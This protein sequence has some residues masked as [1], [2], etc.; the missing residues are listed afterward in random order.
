MKNISLIKFIRILFVCVGLILVLLFWTYL[1]I[2][3]QKYNFE[4]QQRY[5]LIASNLITQLDD[6]ISLKQWFDHYNVYPIKDSTNEL[7]LKILNEA[8]TI[9]QK[10][11]VNSRIRIF[12]FEENKYIYLQSRGYNIMLQDFQ[13]R[14]YS[15]TIVFG[16]FSIIFLLLLV[17]YIILMKKLEP[18]KNLHQAIIEFSYG[19]MNVNITNDSKDEIGQISQSFNSAVTN[20]KKLIESRNLF[21]RNMMHELKTPITKG[22]FLVEMLEDKEIE[23]QTLKKLFYDMNSMISSLA[24]IE[25]T[26]MSQQQLIKEKLDINVLLDQTLTLLEIQKEKVI[27]KK[28][29]QKDIY[30]NQELFII[31]LKNLI[32]NAMKYTTVLPIHIIINDKE[33]IFQS[34]SEKLKYDLEYYLQ[35]FSQETKNSEGFGLG[36]YIVNEILKLHSMNLTYSHSKG[37]NSFHIQF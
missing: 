35:P 9:Y 11:L 7:K 27:I 2:D 8:N 25:K 16:L 23:K 6:T 3:E 33:I 15:A 12:V 19:N 36:L 1:I 32:E 5:E 29:K 18:L 14:D 13:K 28:Q 22:N 37:I 30:A 17:L 20:I 4:Q 34:T 21:M 31:V 10:E 26:T 24:N